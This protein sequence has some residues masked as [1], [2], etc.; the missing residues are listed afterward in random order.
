MPNIVKHSFIKGPKIASRAIAHI[1]YIQHRPG[2]D[3]EKSPDERSDEEK[4]GQDPARPMH[5]VGEDG[6]PPGKASLDFKQA[7]YDHDERGR[8]V[9]KF[10]LSPSEND[11]DMDKYTQEVMQAIGRQKGQDLKYAWVVH[12]NT[13]NPHA[14]VVVMGKDREGAEVRFSKFDYK[15]MR[16]YGDRYLEREHGVELNLNDK[17]IEM[18]ARTHG[19]NLFTSTY[20]QNLKFL[21]KP[22]RPSSW[23]TDEDFRHLLL[24][25]R[26]WNESLEGPS[27]EGGLSL[28]S[29][30]MHDRGR[31]SEVHDLFQNSGNRDLWTDVLNN[32]G[33]QELKDY[34]EK[35]LSALDEQ[36]KA[37]VAELGERLGLDT[38]EKIDDFFQDLQEQFRQE[39]L[40]R[41][42]L[43]HPEKYLP[44]EIDRED[45]DF[46]R[47]AT[48]DKI[49]LSSGDWICKFD[50]SEHLDEVR[51]GLKEGAFE[52][53]LPADEYGKLCSWIGAKR[54][55]GENY[56]GEPPLKLEHDIEKG[57][58][59][60][61]LHSRSV[62]LDG[63][64]DEMAIESRFL[65]N[66]LSPER[67]SPELKEIDLVAETHTISLEDVFDARQ[68][69]REVLDET[70]SS[71]DRD[72]PDLELGPIEKEMYGEDRHERREFE[73]YEVSYDVD[74]ASGEIDHDVELDFGDHDRHVF[75]M[76]Q[77]DNQF[78][79]H[80][81]EKPDYEIGD[82]NRK[83]PDFDRPQFD[84]QE[85]PKLDDL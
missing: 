80:V 56:F 34:A 32:A 64:S 31:L 77:T 44:R 60:Y 22:E 65:N 81:E 84:D 7:M 11:V 53:R 82:A 62:A 75:E 37:V 73:S 47:V 74:D 83:P 18:Y 46:A 33:D 27:R 30:W 6:L 42:Q 17:Q 68:P 43:F 9:H 38:P 40:E 13:D 5:V 12:E 14:H 57:L 50:S 28:G 45:I 72:E 29:S 71:L 69:N 10:I 63:L 2:E 54:A 35:Q 8:V 23:Q 1:N 66:L 55:H 51:I 48:D 24:I 49:Q 78:E 20:E 3:K 85:R 67:E 26:N 59:V 16:H 52:D 15:L 58:D 19:H 36:R 70:I 76:D 25:N 61:K 79:I 39:W 41:D 4:P 21:E